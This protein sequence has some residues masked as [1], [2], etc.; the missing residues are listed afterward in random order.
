MKAKQVILLFSLMVSMAFLVG[1]DGSGGVTLGSN[2]EDPKTSVEPETK[3]LPHTP[4]GGGT[5]LDDLNGNGGQNP[6]DKEPGGDQMPVPEP[7]TLVLV[8][9]GIAIISLCRKKKRNT[10]PE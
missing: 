3:I 5:N 6:D 8:G 10:K 2:I 7:S 4:P 9:S 1:C